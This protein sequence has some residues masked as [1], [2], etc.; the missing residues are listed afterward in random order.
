MKIW[1]VFVGETLPIDDNFREWRY[2]MLAEAL[3]KRGHDVIRWAP[4]FNH[5]S[6][7]QRCSG[8]KDYQINSRYNIKVLHSVGYTKNVSLKRFFSYKMFSKS[9]YKNM[10]IDDDPP[11]VIVAANP[12]PDV[13]KEILSYSTD[14][15]IPVI[16]DVRD[17]WPDIFFA[18]MSPFFYFITRKIFDILFYDIEK[19]INQA[20]GIVAVSNAYLQWALKYSSSNVRELSR[21][22]PIGYSCNLIN[23]RD[24]KKNLVQLKNNEVDL[25]KFICCFVGQLSST[26]D[27]ETI[28]K[29]AKLLDS[30][31]I[32]I[33]IC[34]DGEKAD[35]VKRAAVEVDSI[36]YLGWVSQDMI[37][38]LLGISSVGLVSYVSDAPQSLPNKPFEYMAH[39]LAIVSSLRGELDNIISNRKCGL[40]YDAGDYIQ[41]AGVINKLYGDADFFNE[42]SCNSKKLF[43]EKYNSKLIYDGMVDYIESFYE[44]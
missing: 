2:S 26:Y 12:S 22:F 27:L 23:D 44:K 19:I 1:L 20:S 21:V 29:A 35:L 41:L 31:C 10:I 34:G 6:K 14:N 33:V 5:S 9:L 28:I 11:D 25:S 16:I 32:Q 37:S 36:K 42:V 40:L 38:V 18:K 39:K 17:I 24:I 7:T 8:N 4:S 30:N 43:E 3:V 13:C 15:G